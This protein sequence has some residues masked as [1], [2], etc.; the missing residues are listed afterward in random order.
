M[1]A[2]RRD[3]EAEAR[4]S[5]CCRDLSLEVPSSGTRNAERPAQTDRPRRGTRTCASSPRSAGRAVAGSTSD[6]RASRP[7]RSVSTMWKSIESGFFPL[8]IV[9]ERALVGHREAEAELSI[10]V[11]ASPAGRC[12]VPVACV[13]VCAIPADQRGLRVEIV[14]LQRNLHLVPAR[15]VGAADAHAGAEPVVRSASSSKFAIDVSSAAVNSLTNSTRSVRA[16]PGRW[17]GSRETT[18]THRAHSVRLRET[19]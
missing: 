14:P 3:V 5:R 15:E 13:V 16:T 2:G 6:R 12:A 11:V 18:D 1:H 7:A 10:A 9:L 17:R 8:R 4:P 19:R